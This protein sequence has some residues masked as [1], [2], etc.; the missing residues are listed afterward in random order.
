MYHLRKSKSDME[1]T[2]VER[3]L[4]AAEQA[5]RKLDFKPEALQDEI[6]QLKKKIERDEAKLDTLIEEKRTKLGELEDARG[7]YVENQVQIQR[8]E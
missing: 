6:E 5:L 8:S 2:L 7:K 3:D 4:A 1:I